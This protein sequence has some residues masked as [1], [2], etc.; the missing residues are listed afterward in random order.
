V[1]ASSPP[2]G[3]ATTLLRR[4]T[5]AASLYAKVRKRLFERSDTK[6]A[7]NRRRSQFYEQLWEE[8]AVAAGGSLLRLDPPLL[9]IRLGELVV[10]VRDNTTS[11]DDPVTVAI[12][13]DKPLVYRLLT[14]RGIPVPSFHLC[15]SDDV[16]GA[17]RF[18]KSMG[19][20]CV[21]KPAKGSAGGT[22]ITTGVRTR[23][24]V[25]R[26]LIGAGAYCADALIEEQ[27]EGD[28]YRLLYLDG[29]LLDAVRRSPPT[30]RGDGSSSIE[31]LIVAENDRRAR[32]GIAASQSL[33]TIDRDVRETLRGVGLGLR[34]V[35]PANAV[36]RIKTVVNDNRREDNEAAVERLCPAVVAAGAEAAAAVGARLA[37]VDVITPD[38]SVPLTECGG[39]VIEINTTP[40][41]YYHYMR[42]DGGLPV[43]AMI[44]ERLAAAAK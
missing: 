40:G 31:K 11:L 15:R 7:V 32:V 3:A 33:I 6:L 17:W 35:P 16:A 34:S 12:A 44:L 39:V 22:G 5:G 9:E 18:V 42:N 37:G 30:V 38:A 10:R 8:A 1:A 26:A 23:S 19:G 29:E 27:V 36:V 25:L 41:Y 21:V 20:P 43:A 13:E 24:Q 28:V 4:A 2:E 14:E